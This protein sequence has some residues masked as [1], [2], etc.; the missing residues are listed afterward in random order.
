MKTITALS[1]LTV[2]SVAMAA[3]PAM[4]DILYNNGPVDDDTDAWTFNFGFVVS[5]TFT[6][7]S[8]ATLTGFQFYSWVFPGDLLQNVEVSIT[9]SEFGGTIYFDQTVAF[10]QSHCSTNAYGFDT[11]LESSTFNGPSLAAGT[12]WVNLQN[13]V[14]NDG[15]PIYWDENSGEGCTSPGCPSLASENSVGTIPSESFTVLGTTGSGTGGTV[16]EPSSILLLVSGGLGLAGV[17][18]RKIM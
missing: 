10:T 13:A 18:R 2:L 3:T 17:V 16:P 15:D 11:C 8:N 4:A 9:S 14:V 1:L 7:S 12:Y 6:L 5:D